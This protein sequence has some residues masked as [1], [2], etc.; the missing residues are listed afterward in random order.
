MSAPHPT[1]TVRKTP[2]KN[3]DRITEAA[4][5]IFPSPPFSPFGHLFSSNYRNLSRK[6]QII[7]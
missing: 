1:Q 6:N 2:I 3:N 5:F 4:L 7:F